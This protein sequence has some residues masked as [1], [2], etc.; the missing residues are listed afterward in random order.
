MARVILGTKSEL[1]AIAARIDK[2]LRL[3]PPVT[4]AE[5]ELLEDGKSWA[6]QVP[7]KG[8]M[9][10][11]LAQVQDDGIDRVIMGSGVSKAHAVALF[12]AVRAAVERP[13]LREV[14]SF[15]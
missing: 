1:T 11:L 3:E 9:R 7:L 8:H 6:L 5:P 14:R 15:T 13:L 12:D 2:L 4:W 10:W